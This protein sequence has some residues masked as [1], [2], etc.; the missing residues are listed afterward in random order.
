[1]GNPAKFSRST[2]GGATVKNIDLH[3]K[4]ALMN[5][6]HVISFQ[7]KKESEKIQEKIEQGQLALSAYN[8]PARRHAF[9]KELEKKNVK[10]KKLKG[11]R[12]SFVPEY[13]DGDQTPRQKDYQ[14][15]L[16]R[17]TLLINTDKRYETSKRLGAFDI[18][19]EG[20]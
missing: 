15:K 18:E 12:R 9:Q 20:K 10:T 1:M 13:N 3:D 4:R 11:K 14:E 19:K 7:A 8:T 16:L 6:A 2:G 17:S 5:C